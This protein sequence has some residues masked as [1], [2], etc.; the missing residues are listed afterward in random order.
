MFQNTVTLG[1]NDKLSYL[2]KFLSGISIGKIDQHLLTF[3]K[4][5][6]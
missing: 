6:K 5:E 1:N 2:I 3:W 4:N